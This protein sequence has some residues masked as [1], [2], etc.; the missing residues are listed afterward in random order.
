M[1]YGFGESSFEES[2]NVVGEGLDLWYNDSPINNSRVIICG[3]G[4]TTKVV[5]I[6]SRDKTVLLFAYHEI[7][8]FSLDWNHEEGSSYFDLMF[9]VWCQTVV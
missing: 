9:N 4:S 7:A 8:V 2:T 3:Q 6:K 5:F 1:G